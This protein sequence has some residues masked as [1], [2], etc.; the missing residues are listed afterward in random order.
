MRRAIDSVL[1]G[2]IRETVVRDV[3]DPPSYIIR[4]LRCR[5]P[6][7]QLDR[8]WVEA[9]VAIDSYRTQHDISDGRTTIGQRPA[10][11]GVQPEWYGVRDRIGVAPGPPWDR[12]P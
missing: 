8:E 5:P 7:R 1:A 10:D 2:R 4:V 3:A 6:D 9:V 12:H 11:L